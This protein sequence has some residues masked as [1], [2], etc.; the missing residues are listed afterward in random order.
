MFRTPN[1][2]CSRL[3]LTATRTFDRRQIELLFTR[4]VEKVLND[5]GD[6]RQMLEEHTPISNLDCH[7]EVA[8]TF[9]SICINFSKVIYDFNTHEL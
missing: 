1:I 7:D 8:R 4:L 9:H 2:K 3:K 6:R 5:G